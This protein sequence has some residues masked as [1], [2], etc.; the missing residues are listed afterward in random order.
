MKITS[1]LFLLFCLLFEQHMNAQ[2]KSISGQQVNL[3]D[4]PQIHLNIMIDFLDNQDFSSTGFFKNSYAKGQVFFTV[5]KCLF[6]DKFLVESYI[7][8]SNDSHSRKYIMLHSPTEIIFFGKN[9]C[10]KDWN[11]LVSFIDHNIQD[12][13]RMEFLNNLSGFLVQINEW[14]HYKPEYDI[15]GRKIESK[16][17]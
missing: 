3:K 6:E 7:F 2:P 1:F 13:D 9:N 11:S 12:C 16:I 14:N 17:R 15:F 4:I 10:Q 5:E 8:Y